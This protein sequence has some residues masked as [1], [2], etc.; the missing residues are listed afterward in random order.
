MSLKIWL[1]SNHLRGRFFRAWGSSNLSLVATSIYSMGMVAL[2]VREIGVTELGL[3]ALMIQFTG[4][5]GLLDAGVTSACIRRFVGPIARK[6]SGDFPLMFQAACIV[7]CLQ[8]LACWLAIA[9]VPLLATLLD[10]PADLRGIFVKVMSCQFFLTGLFFMIRPFT[11]LLLA[12]QRFEIN[13][14][15]SAAGSLASLLM[16]WLSLRAGLGLWSLVG[17]TLFQQLLGAATTLWMVHQLKLLPVAWRIDHFPRDRVRTLFRESLDFFSWSGFTTLNAVLQSVFLSRFMGLEAVA[18]WNVGSKFVTLFYTLISSS[19]NSAFPTLTELFEVGQ[20]LKCR[21]LCQRFM[22]WS[23]LGAVGLGLGYILANGWIVNVWTAGLITFP[24][25]LSAILAVW[26]VLATAMRA[27]ACFSNVW[28]QRA[29]M[30][31]GPMVE[32]AFFAAGLA[33]ALLSPSPWTL[34]LALLVGQI[35]PLLLIY[36]PAWKKVVLTT[37]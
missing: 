18:L 2:V 33:L 15:A 14:L 10:V 6:E 27:L 31:K 29:T 9:G 32:S 36:F 16:I 11:S 35:A 3:W 24:L 28:H 26:L 7:S 34:G 22:K 19:L 20:I 30:R 13:N 8:G 23:L 21:R 1:G 5:L 37:T 4:Y 25:S 12:A 17:V